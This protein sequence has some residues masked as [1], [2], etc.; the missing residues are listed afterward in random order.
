MNRTVKIVL[1][2]FLLATAWV[3]ATQCYRAYRQADRQA[4]TQRAEPSNAP[5]ASVLVTTNLPAATNDLEGT[6]ASLA[7]NVPPTTN[8]PVTP[9]TQPAPPT[10]SEGRVGQGISRM[11]GFAGALFLVIV[12][13][14]V[15]LAYD[16]SH[17]VAERFHKFILNDDGEGFRDAEY[18]R[19]EQLVNDNHFLESIQA[20]RDFLKH[21]PRKLYV[22]IRIAEIYEKNLGNYLAAAL[23]YE[24]VLRYRLPPEK[25][26]WTAIHLANLYSGKMNKPDKAEALLRRIVAECD[27]TTS[28]AKA[29]SRLGDPEA[30]PEPPSTE[31]GKQEKAPARPNMPKGFRPLSG[32]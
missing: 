14:S 30:E 13:L 23:E 27:G 5:I 20:M 2:V 32:N 6:N 22:A 31:E 29:R 18:E 1:Y 17:F 28:A 7:A 16:I 4:E 8:A 26:G 15:L 3:L 21:N 12:G 10:P 19:A 25:W 11:F 24:E 9:A